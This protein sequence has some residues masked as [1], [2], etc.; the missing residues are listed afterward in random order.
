MRWGALAIVAGTGALIA[1]GLNLSGTG[2]T[3][4]PEEAGP[5]VNTSADA[6]GSTDLPDGNGSIDLPDVSEPAPIVDSGG[7]VAV[8]GSDGATCKLPG[9]LCASGAE[10]CGGQCDANRACGAC[11]ANQG[12][13]CSH[14]GDCCVGLWCGRFQ[15][16]DPNECQAC[17]SR[18][19]SCNADV[20]CCSGSCAHTNFGGS[21]GG[22]GAGRC[23][24]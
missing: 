20:E 23:A 6:N 17:L 24:G 9:Y 8:D 7:T 16:D 5:S 11:S 19:Q 21:N 3:N 22:G 14:Q 13:K 1:C 15:E 4:D 18:G 10:C 12:T 2:G